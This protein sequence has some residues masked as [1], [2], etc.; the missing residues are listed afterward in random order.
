M[1]SEELLKKIETLLAAGHTNAATDLLAEFLLVVAG[2]PTGI[3]TEKLKKSESLDEIIS[4]LREELHSMGFGNNEVPIIINNSVAW[5]DDLDDYDLGIIENTSIEIETRQIL[6][7]PGEEEKTIFG[8]KIFCRNTPIPKNNNSS[9]DVKS[10]EKDREKRQNEQLKLK[11][12]SCPSDHKRFSEWFPIKSDSQKKVTE[13]EKF[14]GEEMESFDSLEIKR[15]LGGKEDGIKNEEN[16]FLLED[17]DDFSDLLDGNTQKI[18]IDEYIFDDF[19]EEDNEFIE[20]PDEADLGDVD[21]LGGISREEK[22]FKVAWELGIQV[23]W[24]DEG[25]DLLKDI[26]SQNGWGQTRLAMEY[27]LI[28]QGVTC[29]E[30]SLIREIKVYW[31]SRE[32]FATVFSKRASYLDFGTYPGRVIFSWRMGV[33]IVRMFPD[34]PDFSEI[35]QFLEEAY[36]HWISLRIN[37]KC[38]FSS[39]CDFL[40]AISSQGG[41]IQN[42]LENLIWDGEYVRF[43]TVYSEDYQNPFL[44]K[45]IER[46][47][48]VPEIWLDF[49]NHSIGN[50]PWKINSKL[51]LEPRSL[52]K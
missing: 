33:K 28:E 36:D 41:S 37:K 11:F 6:Y 44:K 2:K 47:G 43:E 23:G 52:K 26:F 21:Y 15:D 13:E 35:E 9:D 42:Y 10:S 51:E 24:E 27:L 18:N 31:E 22:A 48:L 46:E 19:Q 34:L 30:L 3:S 4:V 45:W 32:D 17:E 40:K 38:F 5:E 14:S 7:E 49:L 29:D 39:Y 20:G 25:I 8:S 50:P 12:S 1:N 16:I